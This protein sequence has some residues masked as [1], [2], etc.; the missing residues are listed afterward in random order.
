MTA[1]SRSALPYFL[2]AASLAMLVFAGAACSS[3]TATPAPTATATQAPTPTPDDTDLTGILATTDLSVGSNRVAFLLLSPRA[4]IDV[5][6]VSIA[7]TFVGD[8]GRDADPSETATASFYQW[9]F[10]TRGNYVTQLELD[11]AG[12]W[13]LFV[14]AEGADGSLSAARIPLHVKDASFTPAVGSSPPMD[15]NRTASDV[16]GLDE[17]SSWST[18]DPDLYQATIP[19]LVGDGMPSVV[20]FASPALCTSPTCG[21]QVETVSELKDEYR[22]SVS[23]VHV[24]VYDN[25]HEIQG[26]L[27]TARYSPLVEAWGLS[28]IEDYLNESFVFILDRE[29]RIASK[30]EGY[31]SLDELVAGLRQVL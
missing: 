20:V 27:T 3:P 24:E 17:I 8:E 22:D 18:P 15:V 9:P 29:G 25:P 21:P 16:T 28:M 11:R 30:Y 13:E 1:L 10:G 6:Q 5:P 23:F 31:A 7:S 19:Q 4:L 2:A 26:D 12:E 14:E